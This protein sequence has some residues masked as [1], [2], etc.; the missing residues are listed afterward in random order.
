MN[1]DTLAMFA[2]AYLTVVRQHA[3]QAQ[4]TGKKG[5]VHRKEAFR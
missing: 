3:R 5:Q 2:L 1:S 4:Q